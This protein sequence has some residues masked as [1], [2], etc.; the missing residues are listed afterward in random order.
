M[1]NNLSTSPR[2]CLRGYKSTTYPLVV[3]LSIT[4]REFIIN[5]YGFKKNV[6]NN[7]ESQYL[8]GNMLENTCYYIN[9]LCNMVFSEI[10]AIT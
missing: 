6:Q 5:D 3:N 1:V 2:C 10:H 7:L 4:T 8:I 9:I